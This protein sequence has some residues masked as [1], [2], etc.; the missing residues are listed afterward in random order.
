G[1]GG[2]LPPAP[3]QRPGQRAPGLPVP[4]AGRAGRAAR[5]GVVRRHHLR[6]AGGGVHVPGGDHRL[7]QP[8]RGGLAAVQHAGRLVL[9]GD[10]GGGAGPGPAG[11]LQ[12]RPGRAVHGGGLDR[13]AGG[14]GGGR[15]H[16]RAG[17]VAGQRVRR[18][19]V[20]GGQGRGG[21]PAPPT[22]G[23]GGG[24]GG[25]GGTSRSTTGG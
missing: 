11:G 7:V 5:P 6:A 23:G 4:A 22:G 9:P 8:L 25:G 12:H 18:A 16:G 17:P 1:A 13:A 24:R 20:A 15:E 19:A 10:A 3:A 2:D 21:V 14:G